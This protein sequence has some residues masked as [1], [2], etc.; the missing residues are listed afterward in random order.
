MSGKTYRKFQ[1][2]TTHRAMKTI[3]SSLCSLADKGANEGVEGIYVRFI[4]AYLGRNVDVRGIFNHE[5]TSI[6]LET[7]GGTMSTI[8]GEFILIMH[9]CTCHGKNNTNSL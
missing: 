6:P 3:S 2:N 8:S 7:S 4:E 5:I 9:E 1:N